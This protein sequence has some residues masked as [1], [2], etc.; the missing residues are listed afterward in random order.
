MDIVN[1]LSNYYDVKQSSSKVLN[2]YF[3][4]KGHRI[5]CVQI[6]QKNLYLKEAMLSLAWIKLQTMLI[7]K[8]MSLDGHKD[9]KPIVPL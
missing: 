3:Y 1:I 5:Q 2:Y 4:N 9:T 7:I 8:L 6:K